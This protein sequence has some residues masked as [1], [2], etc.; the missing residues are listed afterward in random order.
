MSEKNMFVLRAVGKGNYRKYEFDG[1][2]IVAAWPTNEEDLG[3]KTPHCTRPSE[4]KGEIRK[5]WRAA[6]SEFNE[7][8]AESFNWDLSDSDKQAEAERLEKEERKAIEAEEERIRKI[9]E[10]ISGHRVELKETASVSRA[11]VAKI[12]GADGTYRFDRTFL[13]PAGKIYNDKIFDLKEDGE[14]GFYELRTSEQRR[15]GI[16][17]TRSYLKIENGEAVE[18]DLEDLE[19]EFPAVEPTARPKLELCYEC[20]QPG[21]LVHDLE[22]GLKKHL[23]C[24]DIPPY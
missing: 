17:L 9:N 1:E 18:I 11:Y 5:S 24:C 14:D 3:R 4:F 2:K 20:R 16:S 19:T 21:H 10:S 15:S 13:E 7:S 12:T 23:G 8:G 22:D 6:L